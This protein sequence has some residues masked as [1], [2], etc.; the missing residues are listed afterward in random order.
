MTDVEAQISADEALAR[1][2]QVRTRRRKLATKR[3]EGG[4][5]P[6][7]EQVDVL[8]KSPLR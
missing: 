2:I 7:T 6:A 4:N 3:E 5:K 8:A 1:R